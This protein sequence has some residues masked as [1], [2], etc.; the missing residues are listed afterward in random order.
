MR[1]KRNFSL[2][3]IR[4][5]VFFLCTLKNF[6]QK[7]RQNIFETT[8]LISLSTYTFVFKGTPSSF[9]IVFQTLGL[10][11][12]NLVGYSQPIRSD[13]WTSTT[14]RLLNY[15][16]Q[17][18]SS[19][20]LLSPANEE[21]GNLSP[22]PANGFKILF[23]PFFL[24]YSIFGDSWGMAIYWFLIFGSFAFFM[25][26]LL[27]RFGIP[28]AW[29]N[30]GV[31]L[32]F[33]NPY[34]QTWLTV[35]GISLLLFPLLLYVL[36]T[37]K[38][39]LKSALVIVYVFI[40][41]TQTSPY[42]IDLPI[43]FITSSFILLMQILRGFATWKTASVNLLLA[44]LGTVLG[45]LFNSNEFRKVQS[46]IYPG[47]RWAIN[48]DVPLGQWFSQFYSPFGYSGWDNLF[49]SNICE[50][51]VNSSILPGLLLMVILLQAIR[52]PMA[53]LKSPFRKRASREEN[54]TIVLVIYFV[55]LSIWQLVE[56]PHYVGKILLIGHATSNRTLGVSGFILLLITLR[57]IT[58]HGF[59]RFFNK[60]TVFVA[61]LGLT[62]ISLGITEARS[63]V[64]PTHQNV[65]AKL[66]A[67]DD[68][69]PLIAFLGLVSMAWLLSPGA[70]F[71]K[72]ETAK[73]HFERVS[74]SFLLI[75]VSVISS[76]AIWGVFNPILSADKIFHI[77]E[78]NAA[79][80]VAVHM[81]EDSRP[82]IFPFMGANGWL[83]TLGV[84]TPINAYNT[85][86][87]DY[88]KTTLGVDYVKNIQVLNRT[89]YVETS[90]NGDFENGAANE[91]RVP[92]RVFNDTDYQVA[93]FTSFKNPPTSTINRLELSLWCGEASPVILDSYQISQIQETA[94]A[95]IQ[96]Q[97]WLPVKSIT[98]INVL[99][100]QKTNERISLSQFYR[101]FRPDVLE[102]VGLPESVSGYRIFV[103]DAIIGEC[104]KV[105]FT[106]TS[107]AKSV[108]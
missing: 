77:K 31:C 15:L 6:L 18:K 70:E 62:L 73:K 14:P 27:L 86:P 21:F 5:P 52:H 49:N 23:Q 92:T 43:F 3:Q 72:N 60:T 96:L 82:V 97:G 29:S 25:R 24:G 37:Q 69:V 16:F 19:I 38:T 106:L 104:L 8:F 108:N 79:R 81:A 103:K 100:F 99:A 40:V 48:G 75:S 26:L 12:P 28:R 68:F 87:L 41:F 67:L 83:Q 55:L 71:F 88:W 35:L 61:F 76:V 11:S 45:I 74:N 93:S 1:V 9:G 51:A 59:L 50:G 34:Q 94:I 56:L 57:L 44:S 10:P 78:T 7:I 20:N 91:V 80:N 30:L 63:L 66:L 2:K 33:F 84:I 90:Q 46:T 65:L 95:D 102:R 53:A 98:P 36:T 64:I 58:V 54:A 22:L 42:L 89:G 107:G 39:S 105:S 13:E 17:N 85:P 101:V 4:I 47:D 32:L